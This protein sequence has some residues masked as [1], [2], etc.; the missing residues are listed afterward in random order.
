MTPTFD[1]QPRPR[2]TLPNGQPAWTRRPT[3]FVTQSLIDQHG[4]RAAALDAI[5]QGH[6]T[7]K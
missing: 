1:R 3:G 2:V 7:W 6:T 4:S 5:N